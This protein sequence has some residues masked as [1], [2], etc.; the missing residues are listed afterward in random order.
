MTNQETAEI[1]AKLDRMAAIAAKITDQAESL[2]AE[3]IRIQYKIAHLG[4]NEN[5]RI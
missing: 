3:L 2:K 5:D 4:G 1:I